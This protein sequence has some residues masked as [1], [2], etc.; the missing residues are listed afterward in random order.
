MCICCRRPNCL[1][2]SA[3]KTIA[4]SNICRESKGGGMPSCGRLPIG[5]LLCLLLVLGACS[6]KNPPEV[7]NGGPILFEGARLIVGD[8][9]A[10]IED[11]AFLIENDKISKVG[12]KGEI[13]A[14]P[15]GARVDLTGKTVMPA[16]IDTH[17]HLGWA[18]IK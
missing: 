9:S 10:P 5:L 8:G 2:L 11:S 1:N 6:S 16:L 7:A 17:T 15:G 13:P 3:M 14:P 18:V 12:K 4:M